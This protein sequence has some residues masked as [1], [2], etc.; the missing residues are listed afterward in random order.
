MIAHNPLHG[1]GQAGFPHRA[2]ALGEDADASQGIG[3][4]DGRRRQPASDEAPHQGRCGS[5]LHFRMTLHSQHV[6]GL[7]GA[8]GEKP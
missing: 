6:A 4:T 8:P 3:M 5:P 7:T 1:S 2:L